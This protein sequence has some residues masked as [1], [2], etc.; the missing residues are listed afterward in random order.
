MGQI[1]TFRPEPAVDHMP[2][3]AVDHV[4]LWVGNA[5][6]A[7]YFYER[8]MGF[9]PIAYSGLETGNRNSVAYALAQG[10]VRLLIQGGLGPDSPIS[11]FCEAHG[12]G[13]HQIVLEVPDAAAAF[14]EAVKRGAKA[15]LDPTRIE[16]SRGHAGVSA[17]RLYGEVNL[18]FVDRG[19]YGGA[20]L[21]GYAPIDHGQGGSPRGVGIAAIDH[22]VGNVE[23][24]QMNTWVDWFKSVLGFE[25]LQH[26]TDEAISTEYSALMS[27]VMQDGSGKVKFPINEP[28]PGKRKSQIDEYL[29]YNVGP[30]VQHL[31]LITGDVCATVEA[32]KQRGLE[33][34]TVPRTYYDD[35]WKR[36][37]PIRE[38]VKEIERLNIMVDRDDE[39]YLLQIFTQPVQ[40]RPTLF[41]EIIQRRG[42]RGF[43]EGNF[44]ALFEAIEREQDRRGN[45]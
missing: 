44:K 34:L 45:L 41:L 17:I 39:G 43:G 32:L 16:D 22:I 27:K 12:D 20:F 19:S 8:S 15:A 36:V 24:G 28:A 1:E 42:S 30:G 14:Q 31:A 13:V 3:Q 5:K 18:G 38:D 23:L 35:L 29:E 7:A 11:R 4:E 9:V 10:K 2:I 26:F 40:D 37:G 33:F 6:Q 21:P 25:Q